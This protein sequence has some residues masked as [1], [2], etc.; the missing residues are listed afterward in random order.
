LREEKVSST[1]LMIGLA[2]ATVM[3]V[4]VVA[5]LIKAELY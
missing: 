1:F 4:L 5:L 3:L 2:V